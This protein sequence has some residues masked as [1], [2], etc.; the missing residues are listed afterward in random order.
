[1]RLTD[2]VLDPRVRRYLL[3]T[4]VLWQTP[5]GVENVDALLRDD[6]SICVLRP[7]PA[8][9]SA[10]LL[11]FG[12]EIHGGIR[13]EVPMTSTGRRARVRVRFGESATEAMRDPNN[14]HTVHDF[15]VTVPWM[16]H[17]EYGH[18]AFRFVRIDLLDEETAIDL[19]VARAVFLYHD[20]EFLGSFECSDERLN[21]V[22]ATGA[23][24]VHLCMQDLVWDGA[25]R[26]RL[27]WIGDLHPET[28]TIASVFG[29]QTLVCDTLDYVRDHTP[30]PGWMNGISS[31][32]LWWILC[33]RDWYR[34]HA[35]AAYLGE[36]REY[37]LGLL[38]QVCG[39]IGPDGQE[40]LE[41][42]RF[43]EWPTARDE[44]AIACGL[45]SLAVMALEAGAQ[46][47]EVLGE[48]VAAEETRA[49]AARAAKCPPVAS[50]SK[51]ANALAVLA[52]TA[53]PVEIN[54]GILS[55]DPY[56]GLSTF[57]G[58]Y[59]LEA[60]ARA[61]DFQ[62]CLDL[63]RNYWGAMLDR[64]ATTFWEAFDID[65]L[66]GSGRIDELT[67][68]GLKDLHAD[69]GDHCYVGLRHS[70]CH[71]WASGPTAWLI[72]HVLGLAPAEPGFARVR[73]QPTLGDLAYARGSLPT[74][75]GVIR[76]SHERTATG[77]VQTGLE[78]P[79]GVLRA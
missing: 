32:S 15:D 45:Q 67:P 14:D 28:M 18:T 53:N 44:T 38:R 77:E 35:N 58:Y 54:A 79:D 5:E 6:D 8:T 20:L 72:E 7:A 78:L 4:R 27:A 73:V 74:P 36:Q 22:W 3:P 62:G 26:D 13:L 56:R 24:T 33:H 76:V 75:R 57:Y 37:L 2:G 60:R 70:L 42:H 64:G 21:R 61:G 71:G 48:P 30:L 25:K 69:Y 23:H 11:D 52:G 50:A 34:Y 43:L 17:Q 19:R 31:Y 59:V 47:C 9:P 65:W 55:R 68:E 49:V 12:R 66:E 46:L 10:V 63:M 41:G 40:H 39:Q 1:M 51:Q 16:G 29:E